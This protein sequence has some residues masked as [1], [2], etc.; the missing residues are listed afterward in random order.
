M[1][2]KQRSKFERS[3]SNHVVP[4][5]VFFLWI[6]IGCAIAQA[7]PV[8][9]PG[10]AVASAHPLATDAAYWVAEKG[11]NAFDA[12]VAV[13]AALGVVEPMGSGIG[14][15]GFWLIHQASDGLEIMVDGRERAP[16]GAHKN[17]Y[18]DDGG[19]VIAG[20]SL[21]GPLAAGIPGEPAALV[22]IAEKYGQLSL[23]DS[24]SPAIKIA[25]DGFPV[26]ARFQR[27]A[28]FRHEAF[29]AKARRLFLDDDQVPELGTLIK[30]PELAA[31]LS[32]ISARGHS[33][34]YGGWVASTLV[35][36]V[37]TAGG[38]WTQKD[39]DDYQIV[40]RAPVE[41]RYRGARF[42]SASLPSSGGIVLSEMLNMLQ[43]SEAWKQE[44]FNRTHTII[45]VMRRAYRDRALY[46]GDSDFVAVD[47]NKLTSPQYAQQQI[48]NLVEHA[49]PSAE[50]SKSGSTLKEGENTTHFS[51]I[52]DQGNRVAAT[53][54]INY[55]FGS[56]FVS[57]GTGVVLNNEMDD[58]VSKPGAAN[59]YGL[60]GGEANSIEAGK[61]PLS[62][63]SP[64]FVETDQMVAVIG[65][66][67]GSRIITMVLL[68]LLEL[69]D[70]GERD[71][72]KVVNLPRF[73]HQYLPDS[74][75]YE[76]GAFDE[77][78]VSAL[79]RK[80]HALKERE[81]TYGNMHA[82]LWELDRNKLSAA[83]DR[84]GEGAARVW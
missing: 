70:N 76:P 20:A 71:I 65:T 19:E 25:R 75:T 28:E 63:M 23:A 9:P 61:R 52:D 72:Q 66:P 50:L 46:L 18:L 79:K 34:F 39:L 80:G 54:S 43:A 14:G 33:G 30:Q 8:K 77:E 59:V 16:L 6:F 67:G 40:E 22:H 45:E 83:S 68:A 4:G 37:T 21:D 26:S 62:S 42:V 73:H 38:I 74:I 56:G 10:W 32:E 1:T 2:V 36:E 29:N 35:S 53:L 64:T 57:G 69:V 44:R 60:V 82:V 84:R 31:T 11:G 17:M 13:S 78:L 7:A 55:P 15:G 47:Q 24:L 48:S 3:R 81:R 5:L 12:A 27:L 58:F 51:I 41:G 49:T